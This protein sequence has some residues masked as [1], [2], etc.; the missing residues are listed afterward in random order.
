MKIPAVLALTAITAILVAKGSA[1]TLTGSTST[2]T[3]SPVAPP[4][5]QTSYPPPV[6]AATA[7]PASLSLG[8]GWNESY[9][10]GV[11]LPINNTGTSPLT[12][13]GVQSSANLFV[14]SFPTTV[15]PNGQGT[16]SLIYFSRYNATGESDVVRVLTSSGEVDIPVA[17]AR[18]SAFQTSAQQLTWHVNDPLTP[19]TVTLTMATN[20]AVPQAV[21][22]LGT[23]NAAT[24]T[25]SGE[26]IYQITVTPGSTS[27]AGSFP[28]IVTLNPTLPGGPVLISCTISPSN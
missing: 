13:L 12:I 5:G 14:E 26:N 23:G 10:T 15:A 6:I 16:I 25:S 28:V 24:I 7:F 27:T 8:L 19:Q 11:S 18:A 2:T 20:T 9:R 3:L 17:H 21:A 22:A 1:Q 4:I